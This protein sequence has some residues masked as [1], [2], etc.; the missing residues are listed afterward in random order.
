MKIIQKINNNRL[1]SSMLFFFLFLCVVGLMCSLGHNNAQASEKIGTTTLVQT[2]SVR[3]ITT[4]DAANW[5]FVED[6]YFT[7]SL[8][9]ELVISESGIISIKN[10]EWATDTSALNSYC[11]AYIY[12]EDMTNR[13]CED[14]FQVMYFYNVPRYTLDIFNNFE[15][16]YDKNYNFFIELYDSF[17][18]MYY[19]SQ[20]LTFNIAEVDIYSLPTPPEAQE[21]FH[22]DGWYYDDSFTTPYDKDYILADTILYAK[23]DVNTYVVNFR[24]DD[25]STGLTKTY[26]TTLHATEIPVAPNK[27]GYNFIGWFDSNGVKATNDYIINSNVT[28]YAQYEI[29]TFTVSFIVNGEIYK[30]ITVTYGT[31]LTDAIASAEL[32]T[33]NIV[34]T[35]EGVSSTAEGTFITGNATVDLGSKTWFDKTIN[36]VCENWILTAVSAFAFLTLISLIIVSTKKRV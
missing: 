19:Y 14:E 1:F 26:N 2:V 13:L 35:D 22:F 28:F 3:D 27:T 23:F 7:D 12:N 4:T 20:L 18:E 29:Q 9:G 36:W 24:V 6:G 11:Y 15:W 31:V 30:Q 32:S 17:G 33:Y 25:T 16:E 34:Q 21:G 5:S 10:S 8:F